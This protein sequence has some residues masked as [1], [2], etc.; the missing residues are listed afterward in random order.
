M[1]Y[2][3]YH[4][5]THTVFLWNDVFLQTCHVSVLPSYKVLQ[6][7]SLQAVSL[8][9]F[10]CLIL[11][12]QQTLL[13]DHSDSFSEYKVINSDRLSGQNYK[14]ETEVVKKKKSLKQ[15]HLSC[16]DCPPN[17]N[18]RTQ[19]NIYLDSSDSVYTQ[20]IVYHS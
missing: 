4:S 1:I 19:N 8:C 7:I 6:I 11:M 5:Y 9:V 13:P 3:T 12:Y 17:T 16:R 15:K 20:Q 14:N 2:C 10:T 18:D